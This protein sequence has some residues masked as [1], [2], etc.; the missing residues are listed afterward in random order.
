MDRCKVYY[1][2]WIGEDEYAGVAMDCHLRKDHDRNLLC[3]FD[4]ER[5]HMIEGEIVKDDENGFVFNSEGYRPGNW[6]FKI[7][8]AN[9]FRTWIYKY[10]GNGEKLAKMFNTT[11]DLHEWYR[12]EYS[13]PMD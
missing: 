1:F 11:E 10:I 13:F 2:Y 3:F 12:K 8:T 7:L 6:Y 4:T 9:D 5:G